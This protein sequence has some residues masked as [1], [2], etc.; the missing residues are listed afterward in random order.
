MKVYTLVLKFEHTSFAF[1]GSATVLPYT[2]TCHEHTAL[3]YAYDCDGCTLVDDVLAT[4]ESAG[5][6][7]VGTLVVAPVQ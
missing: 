6:Y 1:V 4:V 3:V 2:F 7:V 5:I